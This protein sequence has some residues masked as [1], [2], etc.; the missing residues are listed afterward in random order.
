MKTVLA[1]FTLSASLALVAC[2]GGGSDG[3]SVSSVQASTPRY[4]Q[5]MTVTVSGLR[6][7]AGSLQMVVD[8]PCEN[9]AALGTPTSTQAQFTCTV[10]GI[11]PIAPRIR[12]ANAGRELASVKVESLTPRV[13]MTV[14]DGTR[15]GSFT[16]ELDPARAKITVDNFLLYVNSNFYFNTIF[17]RVIPGFVVQ[18]GGFTTA[19]VAKPA[20][21]P[22]IKNEAGN[23]LL[24]LRGTIAMA[25]TDEPDS[26]TSQFFL[27]LVDNPSLDPGGISPAG[28]VVFGRVVEGIDIIDE[29][30]KVPT[31]NLGGAF[32][33]IPVTQVRIS[34][35]R[36]SQ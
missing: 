34:G 29:I 3:P 16:V 25:R 11:G 14:T 12:D 26:A 6:L 24:N 32:A 2:G 8:G 18:A 35:A 10:N 17:H 20:I 22:A 30:G 31:R 9:P 21:R 19:E 36:Q 5:T 7:D 23:G 27:N 28:Y 33:N 1:L 15:T 4:S 13:A